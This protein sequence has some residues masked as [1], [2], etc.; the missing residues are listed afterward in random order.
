MS[1]KFLRKFKPGR[2]KPLG[3]PSSR[4]HGRTNQVLRKTKAYR[5]LVTLRKKKTRE[6]KIKITKRIL[7]VALGLFVVGVVAIGIM[8]VVFAKDL[9]NPNEINSRLVA[10]STKIFD[11]TGEHIL[12]EIYG[13]EKRTVV[14]I[15]QMPEIIK[16]ATI[17]IEDEEFYEHGGIDFMGLIRG[18][19]KTVSSG[20]ANKQGGSTITQQFIKNS[21]LSPDRTVT[22]K[23]KEIILAIE[24]EHSLEKDEILQLYLNEIPYGSNAYGVES[25]TK[26]FF[27]K[28]VG[29][30]TLNEAATLASLP[31]APS[32]YSPYGSHTDRLLVRK[33]FV[34][35]KLLAH[36]H[37]TQEEHDA[38]VGALPK[39]ERPNIDITA[40]HFVFYV[41]EQLAERYGEQ[42]LEQG[43]LQIITTLDLNKQKIAETAVTNGARA[44]ASHGAKNA[45]LASINPKTGEILAMVGSVDYFDTA[46]DG[47]VNITTTL[48]QPGSSIKPL[49]YTAAFERGYTPDTILYDLNTTF[50]GNYKPK[51]YS[52][53]QAGP[54]TM[55]KALQNSMNTPAVKTLYMAGI[56]E[57]LDLANRLGYSTFPSA[58]EVGLSFALGAYDVTPLD[59][60]SAFATLANEGRRI[61]ETG[62]LKVME[63]DGTV[64]E[65]HNPEN[66]VEQVVDENIAR[67]IT[68]VLTDDS[69]RAPG[70]PRGSKLTLSGRPVAAK[71]GTTQNFTDGWTVG[72]TPS[73][74]AVVWV[75]NN[76]NTLMR[77]NS[78]GFVVATPIWN[79]YMKNALANTPVEKFNGYTKTN[80]SNPAL[81][82][83]MGKSQVVKVCSFDQ[84]KLA[85]DNLPSQYI[86]ERTFKSAHSILHY[87]DRTNPNGPAPKNPQNDPLYNNWEAPVRAWGAK[88]GYTDSLPTEYCSVDQAGSALSLQIT[89]PGDGTTVY[90]SFT[91]SASVN[92]PLGVGNVEFFVD[93]VSFATDTNSPYAATYTGSLTAGSHTV[94]VRV[95]DGMGNIAEDLITISFVPDTENP[96]ANGGAN[97]STTVGQSVGFNGSGST[98]NVGI[99]SYEW[100]FD[101][102][103][104]G[105]GVN[106]SHI[107]TSAGIYNVILTVTDYAGNSHTDTV[108]VTV[109]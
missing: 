14:P 53:T 85:P 36:G 97:V 12:Y 44:N 109:S 76:D 11:R 64:L 78:P 37:I 57:T 72:Y 60:V 74:A 9:P 50:F 23:I 8:F 66:S 62:I 58:E 45:A 10:E 94:R 48:Q 81:A 100:N 98:D 54:V 79:E 69:A 13:E 40:P 22:R 61:E 103:G 96:V 19:F 1:K 95:T 91:V 31:N 80:P 83:K 26:T 39:F 86:V 30:L 90:G 17:V 5:R 15:D 101:D 24:I 52:L 16:E 28:S 25:A 82:G 20:G 92:A 104:T 106:V 41:R 56:P 75:G 46:N 73:L 49:E 71:T 6:Q 4:A 68:N 87:V 70:L 3:A 34:L 88:H 43:G 59:H 7:Y 27:N 29:D 67:M 65:E 99:A 55:R 35:E 51:N 32:Y 93:D 102:G 33:D 105:S 89:G 42:R 47:N 77:G 108:V 38:N 63:A 18:V 21:L 2:R 107:F 84:S